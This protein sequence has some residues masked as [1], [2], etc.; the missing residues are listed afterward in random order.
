MGIVPSLRVIP[1]I[2]IHDYIYRLYEYTTYRI[3]GNYNAYNN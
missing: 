2:G 3:D 1:R